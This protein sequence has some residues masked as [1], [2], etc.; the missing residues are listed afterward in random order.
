MSKSFRD[1]ERRVSKKCH[2]EMI[3]AVNNKNPSMAEKCQD[4]LSN[5]KIKRYGNLRKQK[6]L[7]KV[8]IRRKERK[9]NN[10][11]TDFHDQ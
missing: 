2:Q 3:D 8:K 11:I 5:K 9:N 10:K 7:Q 6:A 4:Y 1:K